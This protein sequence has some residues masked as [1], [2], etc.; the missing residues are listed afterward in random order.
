MKMIFHFARVAD[1]DIDVDGATPG[2]CYQKAIDIRRTQ[3]EAVVLPTVGKIVDED[4]K[5]IVNPLGV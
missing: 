3:F 5:T 2:E 4:K 1:T